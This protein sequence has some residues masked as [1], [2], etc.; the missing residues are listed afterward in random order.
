MKKLL[1]V[2][3]LFATK[4]LFAQ[5][6]P[7]F[8][9]MRSWSIYGDTVSRYIFAD[10][11]FVRVSPDTRQAPKDTLLLGDNIKVL[12]ITQ[13]PLTIR[14]LKGPWLK[15][16]Y[17]KNGEVRNGYVWQGLISCAQMRR[18]DTKFIYGIERRA[19]SITFENKTADTIRRFMVRLKAVQNGNLLAKIGFTTLDDESAN[20]SGGKLMS[21]MGLTNVQNIIVIN[22]SGEACGIPTC[23]YYFAWTKDSMLVRFPDKTNVG[24]AD[25]YYHS[26]EFI[27][28]NEKKGQPD[29]VIWEMS[30]EEATDVV[31]KDGSHKM[32]TTDKGRKVYQWDGEKKQIILQK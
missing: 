30:E 28:P 3:L 1:L 26:E 25:A 8:S 11:A 29:L 9:D 32:K 15:I 10:T 12:E 20:Y 14:G 2:V 17:S 23:D 19:D 18:G 16:E 31:N 21:G 4:S 6:G 5:E 7:D 27:F 13:K 24:D 22:F